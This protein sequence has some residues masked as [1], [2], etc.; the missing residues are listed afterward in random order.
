[1][2]EAVN[3]L[4][5]ELKKTI[6]FEELRKTQDSGGS[7]E[8]VL[9]RKHLARCY[10][11]LVNVFGPP[12]K[13]F[14]EPPAFTPETQQAVDAVGGIRANQ[15]FFLVRQGATPIAYAALWP[16]ESDPTRVTLKIGTWQAP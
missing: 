7:L 14:G 10:D 3:G 2:A 13:G 8:G 5:E 4:I 16:W 12:L 1:M 9:L 6:Q 11:L 15:C